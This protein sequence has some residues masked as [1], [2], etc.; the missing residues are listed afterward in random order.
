MKILITGHRGQLGSELKRACLSLGFDAL[1]PDLDITDH[2]AVRDV[3]MSAKAAAVINCAA[4]TAVDDCE[5]NPQKAMLVNGTAVAWLAA[6]CRSAGSH[7]VQVSTDY[8][9]DGDKNAPYEESDATR[10]QSSYGKSKLEGERLTLRF[11]FT[12][13]RTSWVCGE[14]GKN[15]VKTIMK[16][17]GERESMS[18]VSDQVG[19]PTMTSDLAPALLRLANDRRPGIFH[20]TNQGAVSWFEFAREIVRLMG[21]SPDM[22]RPI[23][24][25]ELD[26]PRPATRPANSV[27]GDGAWRGAG[28]RPMR[29]FREP[30]EELV[31]KLL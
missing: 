24:T 2:E 5:S 27:L 18:F 13:A 20:V 3:V 11:P 26:P 17:A 29:D 4:W 28:Y 9:F 12:V 6:A 15:M 31:K 16:L 19:N 22:V 1:A 23:K 14:F 21:K 25:H 8:V 30:L 10:P 7:L